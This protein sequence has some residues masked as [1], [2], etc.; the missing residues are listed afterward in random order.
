MDKESALIV[1]DV[2]NDFT[3]GGALPVKDGEKVIEPLNKYVGIFQRI[4][5]PIIFTRDWHP[6]NHISFAERGGPWPP[7]C[8][9][10]ANGAEFHKDLRIPEGAIVIS[11]AT[12][13]D[14]EGYS[15]FQGT[16]L[17]SIL[18]RKGITKL[19]V[20]GLAT[21][22]CVKSTILDALKEGFRVYF[23]SDASMAV[24]VRPGDSERAVEEM[25]RNGAKSIRI[26][27]IS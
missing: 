10:N 23:L 24:N 16:E 15:G 5:V 22:Y 12:D 8:V 6:K 20:G 19:F 27:D 11:K 14:E 26:R 21:D 9:Q 3:P 25:V 2:Q 1:V 17:G 13:P 4:G 7:H 18:R